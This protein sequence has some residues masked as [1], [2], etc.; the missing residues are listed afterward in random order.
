LNLGVNEGATC[1]LEQLAMKLRSTASMNAARIVLGLCHGTCSSPDYVALPE[2]RFLA[3]FDF[4]GFGVYQELAI[5]LRSR[6]GPEQDWHCE[7]DIFEFG[8]A[9][10]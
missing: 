9:V 1:G 4:S 6:R 7:S 5:K 3:H 10:Q 2:K 8:T